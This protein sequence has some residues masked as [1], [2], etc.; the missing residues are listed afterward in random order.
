MAGILFNPVKYNLNKL[1][2]W[3]LKNCIDEFGINRFRSFHLLKNTYGPDNQM[4][5]YQFIGEN[6]IFNELPNTV[7]DYR[8][9]AYPKREQKIT[10][11]V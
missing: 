9:I 11:Y 3:E 4:F 8:P 7:T 5:G 2:N 1:N 6:G 10:N